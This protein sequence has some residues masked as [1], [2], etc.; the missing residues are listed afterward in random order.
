MSTVLLTH[1]QERRVAFVITQHIQC[2]RKSLETA[3]KECNLV[4]RGKF[5]LDRLTFNI[6]TL[7]I[8]L[9]TKKVGPAYTDYALFIQ[10]GQRQK[11]VPKKGP[12]YTPA[13]F[14]TALKSFN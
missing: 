5:S 12:T 10:K 3:I 9:R 1:E 2:L 8:S 6:R 11:Q 7:G 4:D 14:E 13:D